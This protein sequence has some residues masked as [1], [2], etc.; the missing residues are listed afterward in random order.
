MTPTHFVYMLFDNL[1]DIPLYIGVTKNLGQRYNGHKNSTLKGYVNLPHT[2][3][4]V[5]EE[6]V[7]TEAA[8]MEQYW[9]SQMK[10]WGFNLLQKNCKMYR[11]PLPKTYTPMKIVYLAIAFN[12]SPQ[13][14]NRW[15]NNKDDRLTSEKAKAALLKP[16]K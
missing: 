9:Y 2:S 7:E 1:L 8:A 14:I 15:I 13:T 3:I 11:T 6:T 4:D 10:T 16:K 5:L 12:K